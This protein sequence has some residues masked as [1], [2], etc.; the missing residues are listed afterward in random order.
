MPTVLAPLI[1]SVWRLQISV[2]STSG[3]RHVHRPDLLLLPPLPGPLPVVSLAP[4][5][6]R[7][8]PRAPSGAGVAPGRC[9]VARP[10]AFSW[11]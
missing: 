3:L 8:T 1:T 7:G 11:P 5:L 9:P 10:V 6:A 4:S 2:L